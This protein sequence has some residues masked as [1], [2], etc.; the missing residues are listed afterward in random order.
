MSR[1]GI[2]KARISTPRGPSFPGNIHSPHN[3]IRRFAEGGQANRPQ[4]RPAAAP[5][6]LLDSALA[7]PLLPHFQASAVSQYMYLDANADGFHNA[8]DSIQVSGP[9]IIDVY[10][11]TNANRAGEP[12]TCST[13]PGTPFAINS[14]TVNLRAV[15]GTVAWG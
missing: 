9:T 1:C 5:S 12:A 11:T 2:V 7:A 6:L 14:Y 4:L 15:G 3:R 10:L 13:E 8:A